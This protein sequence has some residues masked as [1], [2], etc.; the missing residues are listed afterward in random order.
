MSDDEEV[1]IFQSPVLGAFLCFVKLVLFHQKQLDSLSIP[2][3]R[4]FSL[5]R[6]T[7]QFLHSTFQLSIPSFRGFSLFQTWF[8]GYITMKV[9]I[10]QSPVLGAFLCFTY[11]YSN[12]D[13]WLVELSIPSFR[14]FSLFQVEKGLVEF[15]SQYTFNPQF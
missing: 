2:S 7:K 1:V 6:Q 8:W 9:S 15:Y 12:K 10:F 14:G 5:F 3:F 4:G 13:F 11:T